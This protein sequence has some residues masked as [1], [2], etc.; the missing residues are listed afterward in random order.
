M[1]NMIRKSLRK[2]KFFT[3]RQIKK[4]NSAPD[5]DEL[6]III[7]MAVFEN[8]AWV[9]AIG[10]IKDIMPSKVA[11]KSIIIDRK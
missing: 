11:Q 5:I 6:P 7:P 8:P 9:I 4:S 3:I 10:A 1:A 2:K